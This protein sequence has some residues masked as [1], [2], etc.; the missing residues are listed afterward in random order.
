MAGM[1]VE[2]GAALCQ[3]DHRGAPCD[4]TLP[5]LDAGENLGAAAVSG[6][7]SHQSERVVM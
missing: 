4:N 5:L 6:A 7:K 3:A 1:G 2:G